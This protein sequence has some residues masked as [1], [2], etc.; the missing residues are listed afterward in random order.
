MTCQRAFND[1]SKSV[2]GLGGACK[3]RVWRGVQRRME[4][5]AMSVQRGGARGIELHPKMTRKA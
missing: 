5:C 1:A 4:G 2:E 3:T